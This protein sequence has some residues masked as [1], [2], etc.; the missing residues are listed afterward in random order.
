MSTK[1]LVLARPEI[2]KTLK[3]QPYNPEGAATDGECKQHPLVKLCPGSYG[4]G[5]EIHGALAAGV[6]LPLLSF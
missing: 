4:D 5:L 1:S 3:P 2:P 6:R